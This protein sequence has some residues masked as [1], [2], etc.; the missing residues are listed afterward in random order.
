MTTKASRRLADIRG[1]D[2]QG[3]SPR[4]SVGAKRQSAGS[5]E[6]PQ[7]GKTSRDSGKLLNQLAYDKLKHLIITMAFRPGEY[8]NEAHISK[9]L[10]IG[11]TPVHQALNRLKHEGMVEVIPRKGVIVKAVSLNEIMEVIEVRLVNEAY[12]A[13]LA[14]S[15]AEDAEI[16]AMESLLD[17]ADEAVAASDVERQ[18]MLDRHFHG[19]LAKAAKNEVL[20]E[21][22]QGL[23]DRSLR[24]WFIS[25]RDRAHHVAVQAEHRAILA[26]VKARDPEAASAAIS[27]HIQSF[28]KNIAR[29]L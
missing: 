2:R 5:A 14:A 21:L 18:M 26:A 20:A 12:C 9:T 29:F 23:H 25:L 16:V 27:E 6:A 15:R 3:A 11:R 17:E 10:K 22:L 4:G 24:F 7:G 28:R 13:R 1:T 8:V 19:L